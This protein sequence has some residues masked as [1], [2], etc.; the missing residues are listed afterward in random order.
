MINS[1]SKMNPTAKGHDAG[2][3]I[4]RVS[5]AVL[6]LTHGYPKVMLLFSGNGAKFPA[7]L[8]MGSM[9]SLLLAIFSEVICSLLVLIGFKTRL[10][11]VPIIITMIV[12]AFHFHINDPFSAK[13]NAILYLVGF[14]LLLFTGSGKYSVDARFTGK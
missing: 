12:A 3:L 11:S 7:V 9:L 10:A 4:A 5:L 13:E 8:G 6:M 2:I 14:L 1:I